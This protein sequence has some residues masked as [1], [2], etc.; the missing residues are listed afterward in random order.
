MVMCRF[1]Q[2]VIKLMGWLDM[3]YTLLKVQRINTT[4][5]GIK[6]VIILNFVTIGGIVW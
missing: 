3:R 4:K 2:Y 5:Y 6:L 1:N